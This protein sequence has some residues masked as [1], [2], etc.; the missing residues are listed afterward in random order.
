MERIRKVVCGLVVLAAISGTAHAENRV[1]AKQAYSE[2]TRYYDLNQYPQA[3]EAFK[4]AY[5]N[6]ELPAFLFNIAQC[7][8]LLGNKSDAIAFYKSYLRKTGNPPNRKEVEHVI[9]TLESAIARE[10]EAMVT[11]PTGMLPSTAKIPDTTSATTD[12]PVAPAAVQVAATPAPPPPAKSRAWLWGV[13]VGGV[14][15][16]GLGVGLGVGLSAG[17]GSHAPT[18]SNGTVQF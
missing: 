6:Y 16:V 17:G 10:K 14:V 3:L 9:A 12:T 2:G 18:P 8:R 7:Y 5:W 13:V 15:L 4:R 11:P 1:A